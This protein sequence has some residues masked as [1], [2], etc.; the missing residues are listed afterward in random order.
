MARHDA[1]TDL[2]NRVQFREQIEDSLKRVR[3]GERVAVLCLDLDHFKAVNDTLGHPVGDALLQSVADRLR[4]SMREL[5]RIARLG[6]DEFAIVEVGSPQPEGATAL[7]RRVIEALSEPYDIEGHHVVTGISIGVAVAP[8]DGVD[9]D[10]LLKNADIALYRAKS[11]GRGTYRFFEPEMDARM[12]ARRAL[13]LDLR[14]ALVKDEFAL[15][16]QPIVN[17]GSNTITGCEALLRWPHPRR[18]MVMPADFIPLAEEIG[19]IVP[20]GE[21]VLRRACRDAAAWPDGTKVAVNLS[22]AQFRSKNLLAAV[23]DALAASG[24]APHRLEIEITEGVL[25]VDQNS[26]LALLHELR[27]LGVTI[28]MDDFGTGYSSLSYLRSFP[29]DRIKIDGSFIHAISDEESSLA[30]IRAVTGLSA[31]LGIETTAEG[32]ETDRQLEH[33]RAE[34]CTDV[35]GFLF[36]DARPA[37]EVRELLRAPQGQAVAAE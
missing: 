21:W 4:L 25:L 7:A 10:Q 29:F 8:T 34:G 36:S 37:N 11:D 3:R 33:I 28:A 15:F 24:L 5:D 12:Q 1:L 26:T 27:H 23:T 31:S 17:V 6:G 32:V 20:I 19:L 16:Y 2:P 35:Q 14:Q 9:A 22:P 30:I 18:G 13:E